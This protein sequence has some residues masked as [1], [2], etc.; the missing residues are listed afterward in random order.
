MLAQEQLANAE[1][2]ALEV[3]TVERLARWIAA[4]AP[5][6]LMAGLLGLYIE[7][8]TPGVILPGLL[9]VLSLAVFFW[10][11]HI[12]GLAG[13]E[14]MLLFLLGLALVITE[15]FFFPS[16]GF[17]GVIGAMLMLWALLSS[18]IEHL[19]GGPWYPTL[20]ELKIPTLKLALALLMTGIAVPLAARY[21]PE[22]RLFR[23][24]V[25]EAATAQDAGYRAAA[26]DTAALLGL[27]GSALTMLRPAGSAQFGER[28]LDVVTRGD[29]LPEGTPLRIVEAQGNRLVVEKV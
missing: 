7:F 26:E 25:L 28:R 10:G 24:F 6:F 27:T 3:T 15:I 18:M 5:L 14:D 23:R 2:R 4:L 22:T 21:L 17:L 20:P 11:H 1:I 8:K 29:F 13:W 16:L 12:A 9:G 19:P